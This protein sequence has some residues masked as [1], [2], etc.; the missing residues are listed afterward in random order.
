MIRRNTS[1]TDLS[2]LIK[3]CIVGL[4]VYIGVDY[5]KLAVN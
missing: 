4:D 3:Y 1:S 5:L 2:V